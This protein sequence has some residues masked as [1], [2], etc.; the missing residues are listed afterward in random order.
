M[1]DLRRITLFCLEKR[2]SKHKMTIFF[3][4][5]GRHGP[6]GRPWQRLCQDS[7]VENVWK[8]LI[9]VFVDGLKLCQWKSLLSSNSNLVGK[10]WLHSLIIHFQTRF[11][12]WED[13]R[14]SSFRTR[15]T[16]RSTAIADSSAGSTPRRGQAK[17]EMQPCHP[18]DGRTL[19]RFLV[20]A[21][22]WEVELFAAFSW[23]SRGQQY[24]PRQSFLGHSGHGR[25]NVSEISLFGEV[26][27]H[28]GL[29]E[30]HSCAF[31][32]KCHM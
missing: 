30:F 2:F 22:S 27:R 21:F 13:R 5:L 10:A 23:L 7:S 1:Y 31:I 26:A 32:V 20:S 9:Q 15:I 19:C 8:I 29:Y 12:S 3:L 25:T 18:V 4:N 6:F 14:G 16:P 11:S 17:P 28:S 24:L